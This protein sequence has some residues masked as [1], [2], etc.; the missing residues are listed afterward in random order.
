MKV[1]PKRRNIRK[2]RRNI[3]RKNLFFLLV[4]SLSKRGLG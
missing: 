3:K 1:I 4:P 2:A